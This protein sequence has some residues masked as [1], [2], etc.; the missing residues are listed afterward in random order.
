M[1]RRPSDVEVAHVV[2][3][4]HVDPR[5]VAELLLQLR[6]VEDGVLLRVRVRVRLG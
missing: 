6:A 5:H 3:G 4:A 1:R 2:R